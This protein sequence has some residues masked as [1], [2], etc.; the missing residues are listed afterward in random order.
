[1]IT[2]GA[3]RGKRAAAG[4]SRGNQTGVGRC[5]TF[6]A[7]PAAGHG[8]RAVHRLLV[9]LVPR[10]AR[11][12]RRSLRVVLGGDGVGRAAEVLQV[13]VGGPVV[14]GGVSRAPPLVQLLGEVGINS[15]RCA[16]DRCVIRHILGTRA[17]TSLSLFSLGLI[18]GGCFI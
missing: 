13:D 1:M 7:D 9:L 11:G 12:A 15:G 2:T 10:V 14:G 4:A 17:D 16:L 6:V 8:I 3:P 18:G 5:S